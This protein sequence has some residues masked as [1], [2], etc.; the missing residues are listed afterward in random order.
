MKTFNDLIH[1]Y[2]NSEFYEKSEI[3][4]NFPS[5]FPKGLSDLKLMNVKITHKR[6]SISY[7]ASFLVKLNTSKNR[8]NIHIFYSNEGY[9]L[10]LGTVTSRLNNK[11]WE[12]YDNGDL[13]ILQMYL[14]DIF[15]AG[16]FIVST[17]KTPHNL[18]FDDIFK[19]YLTVPDRVFNI[20]R[21]SKNLKSSHP[22]FKYYYISALSNDSILVISDEC[23]MN[24]VF[25]ISPKV[26]SDVSIRSYNKDKCNSSVFDVI[27][28]VSVALQNEL[29]QIPWNKLK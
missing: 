10:N 5:E 1:A 25:T 12:F 20:D 7:N 11:L 3:K 13:D 6:Q 8:T 26:I 15:T 17:Y 23:N 2:V 9:T 18:T 29:D 4:F 24:I 22:E 16:T 27:H 14:L 28:K 19:K 21:L